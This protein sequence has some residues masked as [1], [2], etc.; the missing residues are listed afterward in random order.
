KAE[1]RDRFRSDDHP[2]RCRQSLCGG[3]GTRKRANSQALKSE[4]QLQSELNLPHLCGRG[5][6]SPDVR[7][8]GS[9]RVRK[10]CIAWR[11]KIR[12]VRK[13]EKLCAKLEILSFSNPIILGQRKIQTQLP[14][15]N[16][17]ISSHRAKVTQR[18]NRKIRGVKI[19]VGS[20][21]GKHRVIVSAR[22]KVRPLV[23]ALRDTAGLSR[24]H[25]DIDRQPGTNIVGSVDRPTAE[26]VLE[27]SARI[28]PPT[29]PR[30]KGQL[31]AVAENEVVLHVEGREPPFRSEIV[32]VVH[33]KA[34]CSLDLLRALDPGTS[35]VIDVARPGIR[36]IECQTSA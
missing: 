3:T 27:R 34:G 4:N 35:S 5:C 18:L 9:G 23:T 10:H 31:V 1:R 22:S 6:N 19:A 21:V 28:I 15:P 17:C 36:G 26:Y 33:G 16:Q 11:S 24:S 12:M 13:I 2:N 29:A 30:T 20:P 25:L 7:V 8:Q 32:S 14:R